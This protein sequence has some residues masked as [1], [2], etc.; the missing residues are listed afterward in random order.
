[1]YSKSCCRRTL[2]WE[3]ARQLRERQ[4]AW[5]RGTSYLLSEKEPSKPLIGN[6]IKTR[7]NFD[8]LADQG[9]RGS[10][11]ELGHFTGTTALSE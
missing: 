4:R 9:E 10:D 3:P 2:I 8:Q 1:M 11:A 7:A 5:V 6:Q